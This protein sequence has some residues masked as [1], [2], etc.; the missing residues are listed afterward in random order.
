MIRIRRRDTRKIAK[1]A[2]A[3]A[4]LDEHA[5]TARRPPRRTGRI[6]LYV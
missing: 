3:L 4:L 1:L 6:S 5:R 2:R